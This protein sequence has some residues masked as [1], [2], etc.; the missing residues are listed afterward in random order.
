MT[1]DPKGEVDRYALSDISKGK[2]EKKPVRWAS[3]DSK[4]FTWIAIPTGN[5]PWGERRSSA[6]RAPCSRWPTRPP[7]SRPGKR[8]AA[9]PRCSPGPSSPTCWRRPARGSRKL[10]DYGWF[11]FLAKPLVFL[12][13]ASNRVTGNYGIDII[14]LT[15]LIKILFFPLTQKSMA[16]M[17]KMQELA[18]VLNK[19]KEKY[20][21]DMNRVNQETMN[22][23]KTYKINPLSGCLPMLAQIPVFIALTRAPRH[24]RAAARAVLRLDQ[25]PLR[26][27]ITL[28]H[29]PR[30]VHP[31]HTPAAAAH[32]S[33]DG[34]PAEMTPSVSMD[35]MQQ[36]RCSSCRSSSPSCSGF[37]DRLVLYWL[38]NN[39]LSIGQQWLYN[40]QADA[41]R[42]QK[43]NPF[44]ILDQTS[45][46]CSARTRRSSPPPRRGGR[47]PCRSCASRPLAFRIAASLTPLSPAELPPG[48][49][50]APT[51]ARRTAG[52]STPL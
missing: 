26:A 8:C 34:H 46:A 25:R 9:E 15:V 32:G 23:Y 39:I 6:S 42:P 44:E 1:V 47:A 4:Y 38:V 12:M 36:K 35:P 16:S 33:L 18:P 7:R 19:L 31:A 40:R 21:G 3:A 37:P 2:V 11:G 29:P 28:G 41:A 14:L 43:N 48:R 10:I 49:W 13:K 51:F 45:G 27:G 50:C 22:L 20:K 17:R 52:C 30:R 24:H 5:G